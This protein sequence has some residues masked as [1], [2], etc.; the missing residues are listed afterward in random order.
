MCDKRPQTCSEAILYNLSLMIY[1]QRVLFLILD[2]NI[3]ILH[4]TILYS[5]YKGLRGS[6]TTFQRPGVNSKKCDISTTWC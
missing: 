4:K 3:F 5:S 2:S 6:S 1:E